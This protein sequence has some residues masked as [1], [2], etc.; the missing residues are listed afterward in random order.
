MLRDVLGFGTDEVAALLDV[1]PQSVK[2]ALQRARVTLDQRVPQR[3]RAPLPDSRA[4]RELVASFSDAV[5][6]GDTARVNG[7]AAFG[8][9]LHSRAWGMLAITPSGQQIA[10][11]TFF[12]DPSLVNRFG[13]PRHI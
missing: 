9:Y 1:T 13:L 8:C 12:F 5:E 10:E 7:Q 11:I 4:E 3:E 2:G 6:A